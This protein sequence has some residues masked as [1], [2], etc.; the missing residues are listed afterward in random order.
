MN[1]PEK[2]SKREIIYNTHLRDIMGIK[3]TQREI[4]IIVCILHNRGEKKAASILAIS[5]RT[6]GSH[7]RNITMKL[8]CNSK[9]GVIDFIERSGKILHLRQYY[10]YLLTEALFH[11]QLHYITKTFSLIPALY[12]FKLGDYIEENNQTLKLIQFYLHLL[13]IT[14]VKSKEDKII[15]SSDILDVSKNTITIDVKSHQIITILKKG[16]NQEN[17]IDN[18]KIIDFTK[19]DEFQCSFLKLLREIINKPEMEQIISKYCQNHQAIKNLSKGINVDVEVSNDNSLISSFNTKKSNKF[20]TLIFITVTF[21]LLLL[22][23]IILY[24]KGF[25]DRFT[26]ERPKL[27]IDLDTFFNNSKN[28]FSANNVN[29]EQRS[30]N[31]SFVKEIEKVLATIENTEVKEYYNSAEISS[32]ELLNYLYN[33]QALASYYNYNDHDGEKARKIL[34]YSKK[35]IENYVSKRS[36]LAI[37]FDD[38]EKEEIFA[39]LAIIKDLPETYTRI[40]Y[41]LGRTYIYQ[42]NKQEGVKYF[43]LSK[44]LG[45]R[46]TLFEGLLSVGSGLEVIKYHEI[47]KAIKIKAY[48]EA[49]KK[50]LKSIETYNLLRDSS[51][52]YYIDY[53]P[54]EVNHKT[55]IPKKDPYNYLH[56]QEQI[57]K[58]YILLIEIEENNLEKAKYLNELSNIILGSKERPGVVIKLAEING[59]KVASIYNNLGFTLLKLSFQPLNLTFL[60]ENLAFQLKLKPGAILDLIEQIFELAK[61]QSRTTDFTKADALEG[62]IQ[63]YELKIKELKPLASEIS[64]FKAKIIEL[65]RQRDKINTNLKRLNQ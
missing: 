5:P 4:D 62:L 2:Y 58:Y 43:Q 1:L 6:V 20:K 54:L 29:S 41:M 12:Q 55:I 51:Q 53:K 15:L 26:I 14:L 42:G 17:F 61:T 16:E 23:L 47:I 59:R 37:K 57:I 46:L 44:Y 27:I 36:N 10:S 65:Q 64:L 13:N 31:H 35:L 9:E 32:H 60:K 33:L 19:E 8:G 56:C 24:N 7:V 39:E 45:N 49:K 22:L 30:R 21:I 34:I 50:I 18:P 40:I 28:N 63:I 38:L 11:E 48:N 52:K 25:N 3:F